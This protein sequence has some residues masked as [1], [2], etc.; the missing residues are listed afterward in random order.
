MEKAFG[1]NPKMAPTLIV[2]C[3]KCGGYML[4]AKD[5]K[6]KICPYCGTNV[7]LHK[8]QRVAAA[9]TA[10]EASEMLRKL[11]SERGFNR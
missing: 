9:N 8:A 1:S 10:F 4:S 3:T 6:T 2:K 5:Q 11:K 7:N